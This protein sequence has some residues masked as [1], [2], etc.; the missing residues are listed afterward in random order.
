MM[1]TVRKVIRDG[2]GVTLGLLRLF[3]VQQ[4]LAALVLGALMLAG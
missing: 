1:R 4:G 3:A 2:G